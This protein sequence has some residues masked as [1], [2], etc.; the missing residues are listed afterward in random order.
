MKSIGDGVITTDSRRDITFMN[1]VAVGLTGWNEDEVIG[2]PIEQVF[3]I[4]NE[5]TRKTVDCPVSKV[6]Q[7]GKTD[8][9]EN[10]TLLHTREGKE[11]PIT[12]SGNPIKNGRGGIT[13]VVLVFR[14]Q[15]QERDSQ[16]DQ[17][18]NKVRF[19]T[20][21][22]LNS[23]TGKTLKQAP[24]D[25][26]DVNQLNLLT[27][28]M[29]E[30]LKRQRAEKALRNEKEF[31][32]TLLNSQQDTFLLFEPSTGRAI[33]WNRAFNEISGYS[34]EEI[35]EMKAPVSYFSLKDLRLASIFMNTLLETEGT[36]MIEMELICK[37]GR[38][39]PNEYNASLVKDED[40][41]PK[42]ISALG[43]DITRRKTAEEE[44]TIL[45]AQLLQAQKME[46]IGT[47]AGGIA[48][49]FNNILSVIIGYSEFIRDEVPAESRLKNNIEKVL[50]AA[51]R[52]ADLVSQILTF[53]RQENTD[54]Q[55]LQPHLIIKE[56]LKMLRATLPAT[57]EVKKEID[58]HCG[59]ILSTPS[60]IHQIVVNLC[61]NGLHSMID[62]EGTLTVGLR[63]QELSDA[64]TKETGKL[65]SGSYVVLTVSDTGC[66]MDQPA[67][68]RIFEPY[69]TTK[70][71]EGGTGLGLALV[72]GIVEDCNGFIDV[73]SRVGKGSTFS[74]Y[75]PGTK[76]SAVR[77][78]E[79]KGSSEGSV[80]GGNQR[81]L[82]VDDELLLIKVNQKR[83]EKRGYQ[84]TAMT[85]SV[86]ALEKFTSQPDSFDMLITDQ[87][88]P[89][90][91]G[92]QLSR[93]VL[94]IK[95]SMLII[96]CTGHSDTVSEEKALASGIKKYVLKP[97]YGNELLDAVQ[98]VLSEDNGI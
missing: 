80:P 19:E 28:G 26:T 43:R 65:P 56:T 21:F 68:D 31:I 48:H 29:W 83:L 93:A 47:L 85:D 75:F 15:N 74:V 6:L 14:D 24:Y 3:R 16:R 59:S 7:Y 1:S 32:D 55:L 17:L 25:D 37:D 61:T 76:K 38:K 35:A 20:L 30:I 9:L 72:H 90:L 58:P 50:G 60:S 78:R 67:I 22:E 44:K 82:I 27:Q 13:G 23:V 98:E 33:R 53:S 34:D 18:L 70:E 54:K 10:R 73:K 89:G 94:E 52:A 8:R 57:V 87:T 63:C 39:V 49:D 88:M 69:F 81:I 42:Y 97:L 96:M 51:D 91:T 86:K 64:D 77:H 46:S 84:V 79:L 40:G 4:I 36:G 95:P 11:F 2:K 41:N 62:Q 45:E 12:G 5:E 92:A 71:K 66:G